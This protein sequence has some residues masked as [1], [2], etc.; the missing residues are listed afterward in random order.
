MLENLLNTKPKKKIV[1]VFFTF[2]KRSFTI[3]ELQKT[4]EAS[5][6]AVSETVRELVR[7]DAVNVAQKNRHR[8][9][10]VNPRFPLYQE[11]TDLLQDEIS[12]QD[13]YVS[14]LIKKLPNARLIILSGIFTLQPTLPVDLLIVGEN[15]GRVRLDS[16]LS[17]IEN[18]IGMEI[19]YA[20]MSQSDYEHRRLLNDRV[21]RDILDYPHLPVLNL[22]RSKKR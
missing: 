17:E 21:I 4:A 13:D 1:A 15:I 12:S 3:S 7:T 2:P 5:A 14:R 9:F 16:I 6:K 20:V 8:L 22:I 18:L 10:R 11:M 19:G